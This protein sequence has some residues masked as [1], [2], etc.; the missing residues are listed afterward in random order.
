MTD[1]SGVSAFSTRAGFEFAELFGVAQ[2]VVFPVQTHTA[3]VRIAEPGA[4]L[5]DVDGLVCTRPG[6]IIGVRTADCLPL[7]MAD[8][9]A[10]I[11]AAVHCGWRGT[12]AGIVS[13]AI[14][15][16]QQCGADP[17]RIHAAMGP[18]ICP[19]C[20]EVGPEVAALFPTRAVHFPP[21]NSAATTP[22]PHID[23]STA[24]AL[25]LHEAGVSDIALPPACSKQSADLYSVRRQGR[26]LKDRTLT[27]IC[28]H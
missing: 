3:T 18:C 8:V 23:L 24:V 9:E 20:F 26:D 4:D 14:A 6:V 17:K 13:N 16:M 25:Q 15:L 19:N 22:R 21:R 2:E 7:L 12:V 11:T 28:R 10:G 27:V 1:L 5:Q